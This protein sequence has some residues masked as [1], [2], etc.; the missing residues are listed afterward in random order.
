MSDHL[1]ALTQRSRGWLIQ[2]AVPV[3]ASGLFLFGV[4]V[5]GKVAATSLLA[6][7]R[8]MVSFSDI[9]CNPPPNQERLEFLHEVR[10]DSQ[11]PETLQLADR[12]LPARLEAA[13]ARHPWVAR[14]ER[15]EVT[16]PRQL[17]VRLVYRQPVL[18]VALSGDQADRFGRV[19]YMPLPSVLGTSAT[20]G[21]MALGWQILLAQGE[22]SAGVLF[23][24]FMQALVMTRIAESGLTAPVVAVDRH[25]VLLPAGAVTSDLPILQGIVSSPTGDAGRVWNDP[26]IQSAAHV[27]DLLRP[28]QRSFR[29]RAFALT[30]RDLV[31]STSGVTVIWGKIDRDGP[32]DEPTAEEKLARLRRYQ[33]KHG[34]LDRPAPIIH[35][36]RPRK[37]AVHRALAP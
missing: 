11:L 1:S 36:L 27:A 4:I 16:L 32:T 30:D 25:G 28:F 29:L 13:F 8:P 17:Q 14:V 18:A 24:S 6:R 26:R 9:E 35:D 34:G 10:Y 31:M 37:Q 3:V 23:G 22:A 5:L 33:E 7:D 12:D 19:A 15:V 2:I 20:T 21:S